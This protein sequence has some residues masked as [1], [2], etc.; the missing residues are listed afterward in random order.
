MLNDK[1]QSNETYSILNWGYYT[2]SDL[3][4]SVMKP[5]FMFDRLDTY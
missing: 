4:L 2:V 5:D 1:W 3:F